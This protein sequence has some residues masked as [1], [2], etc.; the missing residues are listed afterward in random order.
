MSVTHLISI[1]IGFRSHSPVQYLFKRQRVLMMTQVKTTHR[2]IN[3]STCEVTDSM[4]T[5]CKNDMW[6]EITN[7]FGFRSQNC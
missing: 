7:P 4:S 3:H 6:T 5:N 2:F 1:P